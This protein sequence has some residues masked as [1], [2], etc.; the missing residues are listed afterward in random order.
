MT[1]LISDVDSLNDFLR[2]P[3]DFGGLRRIVRKLHDAIQFGP[4]FGLDLRRRPQP[5][6]ETFEVG[7][8]ML[9]D[10]G[11][12]QRLVVVPFAGIADAVGQ[13]AADVVVE[14]SGVVMHVVQHGA[15]HQ[16]DEFGFALLMKEFRE[17]F[18][19]ESADDGQ[20]VPIVTFSHPTKV[21]EQVSLSVNNADAEDGD[22]YKCLTL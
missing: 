17:D 1:I 4:Q 22:F 18:Q 13:V 15:F 11:L 19:C 8:T 9:N 10:L 6:L 16:V 20:R 5:P 14:E 3:L 21:F 2:H 7:M 12:D